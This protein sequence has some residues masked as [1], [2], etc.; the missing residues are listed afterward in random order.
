MSG[1]VQALQLLL[2]SIWESWG[3]VRI[4]NDFC[5]VKLSDGYEAICSE[6][7][8]SVETNNYTIIRLQILLPC[9]CMTSVQQQGS[10]NFM[11]NTTTIQTLTRSTLILLLSPKW[12]VLTIRQALRASVNHLSNNRTASETLFP[13][14]ESEEMNECLWG[15]NVSK[16]EVQFVRFIVWRLQEMWKRDQGGSVMD[17][18]WGYMPDFLP[19]LWG[20][21]FGTSKT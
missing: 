14:A 17:Q 19:H 5:P 11:T 4:W 18:R 21:P 15:Q 8:R 13:M 16:S 12:N 20:W 7:S 3:N 1:S 2:S 6:P 9:N 10:L